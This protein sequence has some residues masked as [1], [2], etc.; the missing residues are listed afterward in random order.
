MIHRHLVR[1]IEI[2]FI[3]GFPPFVYFD[4]AL[5]FESYLL[6]SSSPSEPTYVCLFLKLMDQKKSYISSSASSG[7]A[8]S[9]QC[10]T[11]CSSSSSVEKS[12]PPISNLLTEIWR[13]ISAFHLICLT[14]FI[15]F[16]I[17]ARF[18]QPAKGGHQ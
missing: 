6:L 4:L 14:F 18:H 16:K 12:S 8:N 7:E 9:A 10:F 1:K 2:R 17:N 11:K 15:P 5:L 13:H 3:I